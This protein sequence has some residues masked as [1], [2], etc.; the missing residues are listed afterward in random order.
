MLKLATEDYHQASCYNYDNPPPGFERIEDDID[1]DPKVHLQLE[2]P[3][4]VR[5]LASFGYSD[6]EIKAFNLA[7]DVGVTFPFRVLSDEGVRA[8][9]HVLK[10]LESFAVV[11]PR[12]PC[13]L[14]GG[15]FR[16][17]F[18]HGLCMSPE[19]TNHISTIA[20][21]QLVAHPMAI[22]QG[23]TNYKPKVEQDK[24]VDRW[25]VDTTPLVTVLFVTDPEEYEGG[26]FEFFEGTKAAAEGFLKAKQPLPEDRVNRLPHQTPGY[27]VF[28]QGP[29]IFHRATRVTKGPERITFVQSYVSVIPNHFGGCDSISESYNCV[30]PLGLYVPDWIRFRSWQASQ[31]LGYAINPSALHR[32]ADAF[33]IAP[34]IEGM[35]IAAG[36]VVKALAQL[37]T[38]VGCPFT[39]DK[40]Q[41][42][43]TIETATEPLVQLVADL[44]DT[45]SAYK[46]AKQALGMM[47][48]LKEDVD[49]FEGST[50]EYY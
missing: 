50:M 7:S 8:L 20:K 15:L 18:V 32:I 19:V 12:I 24:P 43:A 16:S 6:D 37:D 45:S 42:L 14:R 25:H 4:Q 34:G 29:A 11:S 5:T 30:D 41:W 17:K 10:Q 47:Q 48:Y 21:C 33:G 46:H 40:T 44:K 27:A 9:Q 3:S 2:F 49:Q 28:Q 23:H 36:R 31:E 39:E 38:A 35:T 22:Q 1:F 26:H 13:V